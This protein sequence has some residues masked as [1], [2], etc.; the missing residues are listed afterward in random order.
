MKATMGC[1]GSTAA[2]G[3]VGPGVTPTKWS[4][5]SS[6]NVS[7]LLAADNSDEMLVEDAWN[8]LM[9]HPDLA[10]GRLLERDRTALTA[11]VIERG[12]KPRARVRADKQALLRATAEVASEYALRMQ[13][14]TPNFNL[15]MKLFM[16]REFQTSVR[17]AELERIAPASAAS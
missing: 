7:R 4:E 2:G 15:R 13:K 9:N 8:W 6:R 1:G 12:A 10:W 3:A 11:A 16:A 17:G 14:D 5:T